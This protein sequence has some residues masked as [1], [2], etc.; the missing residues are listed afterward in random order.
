MMGQA[1]VAAN[2]SGI[3]FITEVDKAEVEEILAG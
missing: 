3:P 1:R 2:I